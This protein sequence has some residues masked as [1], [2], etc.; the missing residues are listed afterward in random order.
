MKP[1]AVCPVQPLTA[2]NNHKAYIPAYYLVLTL[3][4]VTST[5]HVYGMVR[6]ASQVR[7]PSL[8]SHGANVLIVRQSTAEI[9]NVDE[10]CIGNT[11]RLPVMYSTNSPVFS[12]ATGPQGLC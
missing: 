11:L 8:Y 6:I 12:L 4:D 1:L 2:I 3:E 10:T 7:L 5:E 9:L